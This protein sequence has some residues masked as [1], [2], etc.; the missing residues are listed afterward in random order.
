MLLMISHQ[1]LYRLEIWMFPLCQRL[2]VGQQLVLLFVGRRGVLS[3]ESFNE[4]SHW[5]GVSF[6]CFVDRGALSNQL[7]GLANCTK[8]LSN[9]LNFDLTTSAETACPDPSS[10]GCDDDVAVHFGVSFEE[11]IE[12]ETFCISTPVSPI[13]FPCPCIFIHDARLNCFPSRHDVTNE[14]VLLGTWNSLHEMFCGSGNSVLKVIIKGLLEFLKTGSLLEREAESA[15]VLSS[16]AT[17]VVS[18]GDAWCTCKRTANAR[19]R[20]PAT[21]DLV[22]ESL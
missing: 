22:D 1:W 13:F 16:P 6:R 3:S 18:R 9:R 21:M 2:V 7:E 12:V 11:R 19:R 8:G 17:W 4:P 15:I 14:S 10:E 20:W 5:D